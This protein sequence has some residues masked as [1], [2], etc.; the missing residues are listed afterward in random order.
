MQAAL[1][2][3]VS[4]VGNVVAEKV[5]AS[6]GSSGPERPQNPSSAAAGGAPQ[7]SG[8]S[9]SMVCLH[10]L[11]WGCQFS[12]PQC[13]THSERTLRLNPCRHKKQHQRHRCRRRR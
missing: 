12:R 6:G 4:W 7:P 10:P 9:R 1:A 3:G 13:V 5:Q 2:A 11:S 8:S